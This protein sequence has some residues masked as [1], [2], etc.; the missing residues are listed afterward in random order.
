MWYVGFITGLLCGFFIG[1]LVAALSLRR[2]IK[3]GKIQVIDMEK[4]E[5]GELNNDNKQN[6]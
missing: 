1:V 4:I 5:R 2:R 3:S 6:S